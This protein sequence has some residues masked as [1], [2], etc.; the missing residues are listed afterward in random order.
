MIKGMEDYNDLERLG[1]CNS[2]GIRESRELVKL[3]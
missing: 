1:D 3:V 2:R